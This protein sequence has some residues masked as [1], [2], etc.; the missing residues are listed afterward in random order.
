MRYALGIVASLGIAACSG[1]GGSPYPLH[2][3]YVIAAFA[4]VYSLTAPP[5]G[6]PIT[7]TVQ[8]QKCQDPSVPVPEGVTAPGAGCGGAFKPASLTATVAPMIHGGATCP[9]SFAFPSPGVVIATQTGPG[10]PAF[11]TGSTGGLCQVFI[12][13]AQTGATAPVVPI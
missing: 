5:I 6:V 11:G 9:V 2:T 7:I 10:D 4:D 1:G 12:S 8:E 3:T 13:D